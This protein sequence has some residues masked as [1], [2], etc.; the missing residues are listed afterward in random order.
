MRIIL[1]LVYLLADSIAVYTLGHMSSYKPGEHRQF[2]AFWASFLLVHLG[3]QDTI[4]AYAM[5]D[6]DLWLRHL[7]TLVVQAAGALYVLYKYLAGS[8]KFFMAAAILML[9]IGVVKYGER[10]WSLKTAKLDN[11]SEFLD[12]VDMKDQEGPY[13]LVPG[14]QTQ[15]VVDA[16]VVLQGAHD[17]LHIC[18]GQFVG[19]KV[20]PSRFQ[21]DAL[22]LFDA[23]KKMYELIEMQLSLMYDVLYTKAVVIHTWY[24]FCIR[25]FSLLGTVSACFLFRFSCT[26]YGYTYNRVDVTVTYVLLIGAS[27]LEVASVLGMLMSTWTCVAL[28][29]AREW[30]RLHSLLVSLRRHLNAVHIKRRWSGSIGQHNLADSF[31]TVE[32]SLH[33]RFLFLLDYLLHPYSKISAATKE[34]VLVEI[35][36][37]VEACE[38]DEDVMKRYHGNNL[39]R[40]YLS[41]DL[42]ADFV[43]KLT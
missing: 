21:S 17:L 3:G 7:L 25:T 4:T 8:D 34:L 2:M 39:L 24:G 20:W 27:L 41:D 6:N 15:Q 19:N 13:L 11:I 1:W 30:N 43:A 16:E 38:G 26:R 40:N 33:V 12:G 31:R 28:K 5:E 23:N 42:R 10:V 22:K 36:R 32:P 14:T 18:M 29:A 9:A 37:M 35:V